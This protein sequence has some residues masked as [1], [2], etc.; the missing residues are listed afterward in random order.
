MKRRKEND[1]RDKVLKDSRNAYLRSQGIVPAKE[2][3]DPDS[4]AEE[5]EAKA[6]AKIQ[7]LEAARIMADSLAQQ[8]E[9]ARM[10]GK[11]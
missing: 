7:L 6:I 4:E 1:Q 2:N 11:N 9:Q 10:A 3:A 5:K 8:Q